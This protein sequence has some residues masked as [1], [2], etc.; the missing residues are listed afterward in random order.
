MSEPGEVVWIPTGTCLLQFSRY[1]QH[2]LNLWTSRLSLDALRFCILSIDAQTRHVTIGARVTFMIRVLALLSPLCLLAADSSIRGFPPADVPAEQSWESKL[3]AIPDPQRVRATIQK[4]ADKPHLAGTPASKAVAEY[5]FSQLREWGLETH[6]E[7]FE[8]LLP[9]PQHRAL[10]MVEPKSF[11]ARLTEPPVPG[12]KNSEDA[13]QVPPYNAYSG[14]G[15][16]TAPLVYVNFGVPADYEYLDRQGIS[17]K[18]K[19]VIAR[20]GG[21]WR[22]IK[23][24]VAAEHGAVGCIIY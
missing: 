7:E 19:I 5:I 20:Y 21:S 16:V 13:G 14:N 2:V 8:A 1:K 15:D 6:I 24:K 12:D 11:R 23:P 22:G 9:T 18:G 17:V 4:L 3:Q 10:E